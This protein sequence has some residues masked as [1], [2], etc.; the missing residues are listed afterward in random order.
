MADTDAT[1][2]GWKNH[3]TWQAALHLNNDPWSYE[4][5]REIVREGDPYGLALRDFVEDLIIPDDQRFRSTVSELLQRDIMTGWLQ[6]VDW[7][8]VAASFLD[9]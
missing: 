5:A 8:E 3:E 6:A 2:Q 1:Y 9:E 7:R 4:C